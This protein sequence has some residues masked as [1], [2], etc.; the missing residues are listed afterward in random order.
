[1]QNLWM[2]EIKEWFSLDYYIGSFKCVKYIEFRM[3]WAFKCVKYTVWYD[4]TVGL[5]LRGQMKVKHMIQSYK[6]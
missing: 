2:V 5:I 4:H 1:M 6:I 3:G